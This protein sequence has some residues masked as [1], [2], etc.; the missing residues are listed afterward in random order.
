MNISNNIIQ[1][2]LQDIITQYGHAVCDDPNWCETLLR[3]LCPESGREIHILI[4]ALTENIA[5]DLIELSKDTPKDVLFPKLAERLYDNLGL[6]PEFA[7]WAVET[8]ALALGVIEDAILTSNS[9]A[10]PKSLLTEKAP[11]TGNRQYWEQWDSIWKRIFQNAISVANEPNDHEL[12]SIFELSYLDC[13]GYQ[14]NSLEPLRSLTILQELDC[15]HTQISHLEPLWHLKKLHTLFWDNSQVSFEEIERFTNKCP[16]CKVIPTL[17]AERKWWLQLDQQWQAIFKAAISISSEPDNGDL[18]EMVNL[19]QLD[20]CKQSINSSLEPLHKIT[21]LPKN[22]NH[23]NPI[24]NLKPLYQLTKLRTLHWNISQVSVEEMEKFVTQCPQC[25]IGVTLADIKWWAELDDEWKELFKSAISIY[26]EPDNSELA[27][28]VHLKELDCHETKISN[29]KPLQHLNGLLKLSCWG[30]PITSL[31]PLQ[32]LTHLQE[33]NC[34]KTRIDS[35]E[36]LHNLTN[37]RILN[38]WLTPIK[39]LEPLYSLNQ[40]TELNCKQTKVSRSKIKAFK[41]N[42]PECSVKHDDHFWFV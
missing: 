12:A 32:H 7:R 37:L 9:T 16:E 17:T 30:T 6:A 36:P 31:E 34:G 26:H 38:C 20:C 18:V 24:N 14:I 10:N 41:K 11:V 3:E 19:Q 2:Q 28:I 29:L 8:W 35:L 21:P 39:L 1:Q 13:S 42:I 22:N 25:D 4:N 23:K 5:T 40:L 27:S 33:L 15:R